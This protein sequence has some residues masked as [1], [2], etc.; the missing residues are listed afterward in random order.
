MSD[1]HLDPPEPDEPPAWWMEIEEALEEAPAEAKRFVMEALDR[2]ADAENKAEA[3]ALA[4][5][6]AEAAEYYAAEQTRR[7]SLKDL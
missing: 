3:D 4:K 1:R 7:L 6:E 5:I 2:W